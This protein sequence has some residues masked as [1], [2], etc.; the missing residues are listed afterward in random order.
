MEIEFNYM[1]LEKLEPVEVK[2]GCIYSLLSFVDDSRC[3]IFKNEI[4][5]RNIP[6]H[7]I[8]RRCCELKKRCNIVIDAF[9]RAILKITSIDEEKIIYTLRLD[10][11]GIHDL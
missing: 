8:I 10:L 9:S 11:E 1:T 4:I 7:R 6:E 5:L 3:K 2:N